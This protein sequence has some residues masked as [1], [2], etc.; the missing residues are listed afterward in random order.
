MSKPVEGDNPETYEM[1]TKALKVGRTHLLA[2]IP[3]AK[4]DR[5][6]DT[7]DWL[8]TSRHRKPSQTPRTGLIAH[9]LAPLAIIL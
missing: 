2:F 4:T 7:V 6:R 9:S 1:V 5:L 3:R 8:Q